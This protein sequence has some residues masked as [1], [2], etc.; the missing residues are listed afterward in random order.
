V[1]DWAGLRRWWIEAADGSRAWRVEVDAFDL[2]RAWVLAEESLAAERPGARITAAAIADD[3]PVIGVPSVV[4]PLFQPMVARLRDSPWPDLE[5]FA[6][7]D[8][9][10][11]AWV[12]AEA[13]RLVAEQL[14]LL[15]APGVHPSEVVV[16]IEA[17]D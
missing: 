12:S 6:G 9:P 1:S 17:L 4:L 11:A 13:L 10:R 7:D 3:G 2:D 8:N 15:P 14:S 16:S 5:F